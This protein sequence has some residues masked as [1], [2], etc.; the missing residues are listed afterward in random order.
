MRPL[1]PTS[2]PRRPRSRQAARPSFGV[3][4]RTVPVESGHGRRC[5]RESTFAARGYLLKSFALLDLERPEES[6]ASGELALE[7]GLV[8]DNDRAEAFRFLARVH[9]SLGDDARATELLDAYRDLTGVQISV[10]RGQ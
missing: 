4:K 6:A 7:I 1:A 10:D 9:L 2:G 3:R 5:P 8:E